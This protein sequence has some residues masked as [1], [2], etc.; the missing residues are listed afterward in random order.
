M[1]CLATRNKRSMV[2]ALIARIFGAYFL[3]KPQMPVALQ[4]REQD[5]QQRS[6]PLAAYPIRG[7]PQH[8]DAPRV[9]L[10]RTVTDAAVAG[11][12]LRSGTLLRTRIADF[13]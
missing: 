3:I 13:S 8:N 1:A 7:L 5:R 4:G 10:H 11:G 6:Q 9:R 2:E 12:L